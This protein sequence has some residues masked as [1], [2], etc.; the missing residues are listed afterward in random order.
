MS[1][2]L[3][4][5]V[6]FGILQTGKNKETVM[7]NMA[8]LFKTDASKIAPYFAGGRKLIKGKITADVAE[9]YKAALENV[10]LVIKIE[11]CGTTQNGQ[12]AK[13]QDAR[14]TTPVKTDQ[15]NT[16]TVDTGD[17][18]MAPVGA[19]VLQQPI[20]VPAQEIEDIS[21][22]TLAEP[23]S[24]VIEHP[25]EVP[26]QQIDDISNI[27]LADAG[28]DVLDQP[29]K[30][31]PQKIDDISGI[32]LAEPGADLIENPKPKE[33]AAIPDTSELSLDEEKP[34]I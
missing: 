20:K 25:V 33:K 27:S 34:N 1:K 22:I 2:Q 29:V 10:G 13:N 6:F 4:D 28:A 3:F 21:D 9:K 8:A 11:P 26:A 16:T 15:S 24:D 17:I 14:Q 5:V 7:Q 30:V 23:G 12:L 32:S 31:I 18:T 19:N